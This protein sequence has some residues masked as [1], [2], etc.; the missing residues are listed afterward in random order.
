MAQNVAQPV[1]SKLSRRERQIMDFLF[2]RGTAT[3]GDVV[4]GISDAPTYS[5]VRALLATLERKGHVRHTEDGPRYVYR[6]TEPR[7]SA[8]RAAVRHLVRTFFDGSSA[9]AVSAL[10]DASKDRLSQADADR[11]AELITKARSEGR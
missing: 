3:V 1:A 10:L 9:Q 11:L 7:E 2:Q 5:T 4:Q 6:P 8:R